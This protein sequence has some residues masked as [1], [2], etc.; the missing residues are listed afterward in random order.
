MVVYKRLQSNSED[1]RIARAGKDWEC[2]GTMVER[3]ER[4]GSQRDVWMLGRSRRCMRTIK[5]HTLFVDNCK[6]P[7][8][9]QANQ[10]YN[11]SFPTCLYCAMDAYP[12]HFHGPEKALYLKPV[13]DEVKEETKVRIM[14]LLADVRQFRPGEQGGTG[15]GAERE[16]G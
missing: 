7:E 14:K 11:Q 15:N 12:E 3:G 1:L 10:E 5:A 9:M 6:I 4:P 2:C 13:T 8:F 16:P